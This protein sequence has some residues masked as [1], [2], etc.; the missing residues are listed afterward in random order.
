MEMEGEN[1]MLRDQGVLFHHM[2][3]SSSFP[4]HLEGA[5]EIEGSYFITC[6]RHHRPSSPSFYLVSPSL[7]SLH[8]LAVVA[9][10]VRHVP[11]ADVFGGMA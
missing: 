9:K 10:T 6:S 3:P 11:P 1:L 4:C 5:E 8:R 2:Q 7:D